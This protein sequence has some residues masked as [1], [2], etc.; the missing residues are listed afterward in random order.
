MP[1]SFDSSTLPDGTE[2]TIRPIGPED[3]A[4]LA[5]GFEKLS[6]E[7]RYRR[8]FSPVS[9]LGDRELDYLTQVDHHDHEALV[10]VETE[11]GEG[12]AVARFVRLRDDLAEPAIAV[13]DDWQRRGVAGVL[14][15]ALARR[16]REEGIQQFIAPILAENA[17]AIK[18]FHRLGA[19]TASYSG[20]EVELTIDLGEPAEATPAL[21]WLLRA[22]ASG[23][24]EPARSIWELLLRQRPAPEGFGEAIVVGVD[25]SEVSRGAVDQGRELA[26]ALGLP[27][28]LVGTFRP[29][30][31][32]RSAIESAVREAERGLRDD[33]IEVTVRLGRGDPAFAILYV[34][35][36]AQAGLIVLGSPAPP[37]S[38]PLLGSNVWNS[39]A[40]NTQ[41]SVLIARAPRSD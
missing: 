33:G 19:T 32:D 35:V 20:P 31:D 21:R 12:V 25:D 26:R 13:A 15:D 7:S 29:L 40:H 5:E 17:G 22:I 34:A 14:L 9:T 27:I 38:S 16:A 18:A 1:D 41:C 4:A 2:I 8:F 6:P 24:V 3:R 37:E 28:H 23:L 11:S 30:L 10:A 39:V 36:R